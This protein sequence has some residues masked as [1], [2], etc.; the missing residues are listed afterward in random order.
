VEKR[1]QIKAKLQR[2]TSRSSCARRG[3]AQTPG[4]QGEQIKNSSH[5]QQDHFARQNI[6]VS[7]VL[8]D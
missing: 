2:S 8:S 5:K 6:V 7:L 1:K 3:R 4:A